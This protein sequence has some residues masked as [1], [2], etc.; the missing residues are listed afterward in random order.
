MLRREILV[1]TQRP[2]PTVSE[3]QVRVDGV[4]ARRN[5]VDAIDATL[6][7]YRR[8]RFR[9]GICQTQVRLPVRARHG[10]LPFMSDGDARALRSQHY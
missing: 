5:P 10:V 3:L 7:S 4:N 6:R 9:D 1:L 2:F 8:D